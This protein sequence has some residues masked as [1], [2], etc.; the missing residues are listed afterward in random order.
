MQLLLNTVW[1]EDILLA[2]VDRLEALVLPYVS[3]AST[4]SENVETVR[5]F[6]RDRRGQIQPELDAGGGVATITPAATWCI[7]ATGIIDASFE[8]LW[9]DDISTADIFRT[10]DATLSVTWEGEE[11]AMEPPGA[12]AGLNE[13]GEAV[14][15][16][17]ARASRVDYYQLTITL[18]ELEW[19]APGTYEVDSNLTADAVLEYLDTR[20][21]APLY[22]LALIFN[23]TLVLEEA[24]PEAGAP[25]VGRM[26]GEVF[27]LNDRR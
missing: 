14:I 1:N 8:T 10:G 25:L 9:L 16:V 20:L 13:Y 24:S 27:E 23:G 26:T 11:I 2:E 18:P 17:S 12:V 4:V 15:V 6:I 7:P 19:V 22:P 3:D 21:P 5:T